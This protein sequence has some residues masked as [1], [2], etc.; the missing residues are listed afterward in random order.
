M[1]AAESREREIHLLG[2]FI[3]AATECGSVSAD[4]ARKDLLQATR[5]RARGHRVDR[6]VDGLEEEMRDGSR[7]PG[8]ATVARLATLGEERWA[9]LGGWREARWVAA[10]VEAAWRSPSSPAARALLRAAVS[11]AVGSEHRQCAGVVRE[12]LTAKSLTAAGS[13]PAAIAACDDAARLAAGNR[14]LQA[15]ALEMRGDTFREIDDADGEMD[16]LVDEDRVFAN[17]PGGMVEEAGRLEVLAADVGPSSTRR[18][19]ELLAHASRLGVLLTRRGDVAGARRVFG[20]FLRCGRRHW[21]DPGQPQL[22]TIQERLERL[23]ASPISAGDGR[24]VIRVHEPER[25]YAGVEAASIGRVVADI[26]TTA[27]D[28]VH[29]VVLAPVTG[30]ECRFS[31]DPSHGGPETQLMELLVAVVGEREYAGLGLRVWCAES[32]GDGFHNGEPW[33]VVE[34][35]SRERS[36]DGLVFGIRL[37]VLGA[38][39]QVSVYAG[40]EGSSREMERVVGTLRELAARDLIGIPGFETLKDRVTAALAKAGQALTSRAD[41]RRDSEFEDP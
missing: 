10:S 26:E 33:L 25:G 14:H 41:A 19:G 18:A 1:N 29:L 37:A 15:L 24:R 8:E 31:F 28:V 30:R 4:G 12:L 5:L 35:G 40:V 6:I 22:G 20:Q 36:L 23:N 11:G 13:H 2:E 34:H 39:L 17:L 27:G 38:E 3:E 32:G 7:T 21:V 9:E 16:S